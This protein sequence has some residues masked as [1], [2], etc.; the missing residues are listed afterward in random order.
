[1]T[2][3]TIECVL[4]VLWLFETRVMRLK[5]DQS[6]CSLF[7]SNLTERTLNNYKPS[8]HT[9]LQLFLIQRLFVR[10]L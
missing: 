5:L 4:R 9:L 3:I 10:M 7:S 1:M 2:D 8:K 6:R